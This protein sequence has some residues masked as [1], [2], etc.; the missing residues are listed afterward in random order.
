M[1]RREDLTVILESVVS[2]MTFPMIIEDVVVNADLTISIQVCDLRHSEPGRVV[3]IGG[4]DYT[5]ISI[6]DTTNIMVL[7]AG[8]AITVT[9]FDLYGVYFFNGAPIDVEKQVI[10]IPNATNKTPMIFLLVPY[11]EKVYDD[12]REAKDRE[13]DVSL[14]FLT[15]ANW[16]QWTT[17]GIMEN[18]VRPMGRLQQQFQD[19]V[20]ADNR[21]NPDEQTLVLTPRI[22]FGVYVNNKGV[23]KAFQAMDLSGVQEDI[24]LE[25][26]KP[27]NP[28]NC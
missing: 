22:K 21:F 26:W 3:T 7:S 4:N 18:A 24:T 14:F 27:C 5:I 16:D 11:R 9:T 8:P 17:N 1:N 2:S 12:V 10:E 20:R 19:T 13:S 15:Q 23:Q 28:I 6:D 25:L